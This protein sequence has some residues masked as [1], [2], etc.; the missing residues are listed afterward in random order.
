MLTLSPPSY[1]LYP[2]PRNSYQHLKIQYK[3]K[4]KTIIF[5]LTV[6]WPTIQGLIPPDAILI[7]PASPRLTFL[8]AHMYLTYLLCDRPLRL[9]PGYN[10]AGVDHLSKDIQRDSN[11][12]SIVGA[13]R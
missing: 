8:K 7:W 1:L 4:S 11:T 3:G 12:P 13:Y 9:V 10:Q 6:V 5:S 2:I